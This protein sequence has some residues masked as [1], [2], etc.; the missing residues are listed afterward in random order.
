MREHTYDHPTCDL[1][2]LAI[3]HA[4]EAMMVC[5][6]DGLIVEVN[7]ALLHDHRLR[8]G[9]GRRRDPAQTYWELDEVRR[10]EIEAT[11]ATQGH[12]KRRGPRAPQGRP[13]SISN[14]AASA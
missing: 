14:R 6:A 8:P 10:V 13:W 9:R 2:A 4:A 7:R 12:W 11:L 3:E 5:D 1:V